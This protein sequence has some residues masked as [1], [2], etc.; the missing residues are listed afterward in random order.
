MEQMFATDLLMERYKELV[1]SKARTYFLIGADR[2]DVVQEGMIGLSA[3]ISGY[4]EDKGMSFKNFA[5]LCVKR[6]IFDAVKKYNG[7]KNQPMNGYVSLIGWEEPLFSDPEEEVLQSER[8]L[9]L[10]K[11]V[12]KALSH[13]E[14]HV[15]K[16]YLEGL[17]S[18]EICEAIGKD[19][20]SVDNAVQRSK[21]KLRAAIS[22]EKK[23]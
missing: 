2:D 20:K 11:L 7:K 8:S 5:C 12:G 18:E 9:E 19:S 1:R 17:S 22:A 4:S 13:F 15:F 23:L 16:L 14:F 10:W 6:K 3:A 21:K